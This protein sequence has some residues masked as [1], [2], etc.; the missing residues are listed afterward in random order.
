MR[1]PAPNLFLVG[2]MKAGTT[3]LGARLA[4]HPEIHACPIKEPNHF[5][6]ELHQARREIAA[7]AARSGEPIEAYLARPR[8]APR[9]HAYVAKAEDYREL[10]R[11]WEGEPWLLDAST[12]YLSSPAAPAA[13]AAASPEAR[14]IVA[15]RDPAER[16][17]SEFRMNRALG[18]AGADWRAALRREAEETA[19][20]GWPLFERYVHAGRY[21]GHLARWRA[22]FP[23]DRILTLEFAALRAAPE[24]AL[25]EVRAFLGL[26]APFPP[27][28]PEAVNVAT[29]PRSE[30]LNQIV[31][32]SG[33]RR[34]AA[35]LLPARAKAGLKAWFLPPAPPSPPPEAFRAALAAALAAPSPP[36]V[37]GADRETTPAGPGG[38]ASGG[39]SR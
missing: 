39:E 14:I 13:I 7:A 33:A 28:P 17:W 26:S 25:A 9:H 18:I 27:A 32:R 4:A 24:R 2:A 35:R 8:L 20:R 34:L 29:A 3:W 6:A 22:V 11:E 16:A 36:G 19:R 12:T 10:F 15:L 23:E 5:C 37:A 31:H 38:G 30:F 21:E 1:P